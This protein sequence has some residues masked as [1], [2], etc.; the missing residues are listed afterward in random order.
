MITKNKETIEKLQKKVDRAK[1]CNCSSYPFELELEATIKTSIEW[2][3][4]EISFLENDIDGLNSSLTDEAV[5]DKLNQLKSHLKWL[6]EQ[7]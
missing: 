1:E 5:K 6:K 7:K 2:C 4:D 3:E